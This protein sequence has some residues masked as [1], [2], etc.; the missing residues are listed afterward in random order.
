MISDNEV[1]RVW[2][3]DVAVHLQI[4][5]RHLLGLTEDNHKRL[6]CV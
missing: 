1:E 3:L 6:H 5:F 2:K 4:I